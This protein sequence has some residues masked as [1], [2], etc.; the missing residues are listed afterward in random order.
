MYRDVTFF[1]RQSASSLTSISAQSM[2]RSYDSESSRV[3]S[4]PGHTR[5]HVS[6]EARWSSGVRDSTATMMTGKVAIFLLV[7]ARYVA[8]I[9]ENIHACAVPIHTTCFTL[10]DC[11]IRW[12]KGTVRVALFTFFKNM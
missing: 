1:I 5:S 8:W 11:K 2:V 9:P 7:M 3:Q 10:P 6:A 4:Q 12:V